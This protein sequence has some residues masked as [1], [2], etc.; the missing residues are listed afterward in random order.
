M[1]RIV[2]GMKTPFGPPLHQVVYR[3]CAKQRDISATVRYMQTLVSALSWRKFVPNF[4]TEL[5][6]PG[7]Y[8]QEEMA[9]G[10]RPGRRALRIPLVWVAIQR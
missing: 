5:Y 6:S 3:T 2:L 4:R 9:G 1:K 7:W 8:V 10:W